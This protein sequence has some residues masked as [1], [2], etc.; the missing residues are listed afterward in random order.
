MNAIAQLEDRLA[1]E[2]VLRNYCRGVDRADAD[3]IASAYHADAHDDHGNFKGS[4]HDFARQLLQQVG[5]RW[6]AS[7]HQLH[8][9]NIEFAQDT[10]WVE[11]YFTAYHRVREKDREQLEVFGGRY[12][13][14]FEQRSGRWAISQRTVV[15]DWSKV[16]QVA[17]AYPHEN[18][19]QGL[20]SGAD[21]SYTR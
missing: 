6:L 4:G 18:F 9:T 11:T 21:L 14:Q 10:A 16:E 2:D 12:I 1:I 19:V 3:L 13:D 15:Y 8:Q 5:E 7:Q 20:R 17:R